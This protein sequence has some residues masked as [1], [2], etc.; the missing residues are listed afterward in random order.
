MQNVLPKTTSNEGALV[1]F[2]G[3]LGSGLT[4]AGSIVVDALMTR[5][6]AKDSRYICMMGVACMSLGFG[7]ASAC[8]EVWQ[9]LMTQGLLYGIGSSLL[10]Y[11]VLSTTPEYFTTHRGSAMVFIL[12]G[13]GIAGLVFSLLICFLLTKMGPRCTLRLL[14]FLFLVVALQIAATVAPS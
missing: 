14:S 6:G 4:W 13:A 1:A 8:T 3:T 11:L 5:L 2:V 12:L 10:Y 9:L 7:M